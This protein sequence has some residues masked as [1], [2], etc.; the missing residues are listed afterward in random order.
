MKKYP[1]N[2]YKFKIILDDGKEISTRYYCTPQ[3]IE[4]REFFYMSLPGVK[5]VTS[6]IEPWIFG[7]GSVIQKE[8][9]K[10]GSIPEMPKEIQGELF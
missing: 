9:I 2:M 4:E 3:E 10:K 6:D 5:I 1:E 8:K 7:Q